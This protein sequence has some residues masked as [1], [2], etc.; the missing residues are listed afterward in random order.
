M[1]E[2]ADLDSLWD[3]SDYSLDNYVSEPPT[4]QMIRETQVALGYKLPASYVCLMKRH[5][6]GILRRT[7][8]PIDD[9]FPVMIE[10]IYGIGRKK[11]CS[12]LG[13]YSTAFWVEEW[14]YP[15]IGIA[16]ADT[17]SAGHDMIFL[18]YRQCGRD[19]EPRVV[20]VDQE[21][22]YEITV[23]ADNFEEFISRLRTDTELGL[24]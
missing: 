18:D 7:C 13:I 1:F 2:H 5:N 12:L 16:I 19:G 21:A 8:C 3:D 6:G 22:D 24:S 15:D 23:L 14:E 4:D 9:R 10:G 17:P 11:P 20:V